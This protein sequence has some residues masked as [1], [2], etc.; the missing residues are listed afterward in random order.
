[1]GELPTNYLMCFS[2]LPRYEEGT[3][4][5]YSRASLNETRIQADCDPETLCK[6]LAA[7]R[8]C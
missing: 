4:R 6:V 5:S 8:P 1:M 3:S 2:F 7:L